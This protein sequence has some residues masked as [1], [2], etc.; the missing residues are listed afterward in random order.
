MIASETGELLNV[1]KTMRNF[2]RDAYQLTLKFRRDSG[3]VLDSAR[4][5]QT[6]LKFR[7]ARYCVASAI[8]ACVRHRKINKFLWFSHITPDFLIVLLFVTS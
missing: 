6:R 4:D 5:F 1:K 2:R 7:I 8:I 3:H